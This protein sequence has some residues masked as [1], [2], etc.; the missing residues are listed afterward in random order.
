MC[1]LIENYI[2]ILQLLNNITQM[3]IK[4]VEKRKFA[5]EEN[6]Q[7]LPDSQRII[8]S[9]RIRVFCAAEGFF[10]CRDTESSKSFTSIP[11]ADRK[12]SQ[13]LRDSRI[14]LL[15]G[16]HLLP[17]PIQNPNLDH[18]F[19]AAI[20]PFANHLILE[21]QTQ[22]FSTAGLYGFGFDSINT[23]QAIRAC[24]KHKIPYQ[25]AATCIEGGN[26]FIFR[27]NGKPK[28][29]VGEL[30]VCLSRISLLEQGFFQNAQI[31]DTIEPSLYAYRIA[32]NSVLYLEKKIPLV[33]RRKD[34]QTQEK[35]EQIL[36]EDIE[37]RKLL[38]APISAS[39]RMEYFEKAKIIEWQIGFT[40]KK[41]AEEL[42][43]SLSD[44]IFIPQST[45]HID[46]ELTVTPQGA[47]WLNDDEQVLELLEQIPAS[48]PEEYP[49]IREYKK[50]AL[51]RKKIFQGIQETRQ[52]LLRQ[53]EIQILLIPGIFDA[54]KNKFTSC[55][56]YCNGIFI[57]S[58]SDDPRIKKRRLEEGKLTYITTGPSLTLSCYEQECK[59]H[60]LFEQFFL[61][62]CSNFNLEAVPN[63]SQFLANNEGG[64]HCLTIEDSILT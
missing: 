39:H 42:R 38:I 33:Q 62:N 57:P 54:S 15:D 49:L 16:T 35:K 30:S 12:C 55:L 26:C 4:A 1:I 41:M 21:P 5:V 7:P 32:R 64:V 44:I 56:N 29:I 20:P 51:V 17:C 10:K 63:L 50:T 40:Q 6:D 14:P 52:E 36:L 37:Y 19:L 48:S 22:V 13:F 11:L 18:I 9:L 58:R 28:A 25:R 3:S 59:V 24:T 60:D 53:S 61:E 45:F 27:L 2:I 23:N 47:V 31:P 34:C 43:L 8:S 46:M